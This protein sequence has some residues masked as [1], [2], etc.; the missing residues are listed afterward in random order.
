M[1]PASILKLMRRL[2]IVMVALAIACA[3]AA[4]AALA[5]A[6]KA[7][8]PIINGMLLINGHDG[9]RPLD[10][11]PGHDPFDH[12]DPSYSC[13][14]IHEN[15]FCFRGGDDSLGF[16]SVHDRNCRHTYDCGSLHNNLV[17]SDGHHNELLGGHGN[18]TIHAGPNGDVIW[19]DYKPSGWRPTQVNHL[20]GGPGN[21][22]IYAAHGTSYIYTGRGHDV[23]HAHFGR[24]VIHCGS[25][26]DIVYL[27]HRSRKRYKLVG[28]RIISYRSARA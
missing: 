16:V 4:P 20:Y 27:S 21:D 9:N 8:W 17:P 19:G 6:S 13:D 22:V 1:G 24:G 14:E 18:N 25:P 26:T 12:T 2:P 28:C 5:N 10:G 11:R 7:D 23:V 3:L 15:T